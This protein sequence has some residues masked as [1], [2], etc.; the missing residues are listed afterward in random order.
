MMVFL[1]GCLTGILLGTTAML[2]I[3]DS[4]TTDYKT[5]WKTATDLLNADPEEREKW[6]QHELAMEE[7][8]QLA[9]I[10]ERNRQALLQASTSPEDRL[11]AE[12]DRL[13]YGYPPKDNLSGLSPAWRNRFNKLRM[14]Y[15]YSPK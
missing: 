14:E 13:D 8:K 12:K 4:I 11:S 1:G 6:R 15:G 5:R 7:K 3:M 2:A 10:D 9:I